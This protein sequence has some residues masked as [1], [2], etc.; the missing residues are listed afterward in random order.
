MNCARSKRKAT[1]NAHRALAHQIKLLAHTHT[2]KY[3]IK[4]NPK[5]RKNESRDQA[6][7][8]SRAPPNKIPHS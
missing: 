2:H 8:I 4:Y 7:G 6:Q 5:A 3:K 1:T